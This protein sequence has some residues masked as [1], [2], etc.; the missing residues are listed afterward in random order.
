MHLHVASKVK[1]VII[2]GCP[3]FSRTTL[4]AAHVKTEAL[5]SRVI[6]RLKKDLTVKVP[7]PSGMTTNS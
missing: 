1:S 2:G 3:C 5:K 7:F 6:V 4:L